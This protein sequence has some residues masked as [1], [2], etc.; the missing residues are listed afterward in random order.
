[1]VGGSLYERTVTAGAFIVR[2]SLRDLYPSDGGG[3]S[4][5]L[6]EEQLNLKAKGPRAA[7]VR[8]DD[9]IESLNVGIHCLAADVQNLAAATTH[10]YR[11][12]IPRGRFPIRCHD[13]RAG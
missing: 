4:L 7:L 10:R 8:P 1:M 12:L 3:E 13:G 6:R 2:L 11:P 5:F 9:I